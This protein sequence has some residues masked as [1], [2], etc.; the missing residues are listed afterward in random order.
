MTVLT[1][2]VAVVI[3]LLATLLAFVAGYKSGY[4]GCIEKFRETL[5]VFKNA[6]DMA[7][8]MKK[9]KEGMA[10]ADDC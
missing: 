7:E 2:I 6:V 10:H 1:V 4:I 3:F 5:E 8:E 9:K